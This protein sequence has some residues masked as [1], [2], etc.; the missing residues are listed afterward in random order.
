MRAAKFKEL[1][2]ASGLERPN[3]CFRRRLLV[4]RLGYEQDAKDRRRAFVFARY[5]F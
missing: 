3:F 1:L 5:C 4:L 2:S